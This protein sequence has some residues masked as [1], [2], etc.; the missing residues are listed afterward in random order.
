[1]NPDDPKLKFFISIF[2]AIMSSNTAFA[3]QRRP[4]NAPFFEESVQVSGTAHLF[5]TPSLNI[6]CDLDHPLKDGKGNDKE[7]VLF[8]ERQR[9]SYVSVFLRSKGASILR[10]PTSD[11]GG[12]PFM[13]DPVLLYNTWWGNDSFACLSKKDGL[14]CKNREG[15]GFFINSEDIKTF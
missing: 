14:K 10:E 1:M 2:V 5:A 7:T 9:P 6:T 12:G 15:H 3:E 11:T 4:T 13:S 8:C